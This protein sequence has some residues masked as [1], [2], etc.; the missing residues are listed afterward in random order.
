MAGEI[1]P[2][3]LQFLV[4]RM[5]SAVTPQVI[6]GFLLGLGAQNLSKQLKPKAPPR[7]T[8]P[9]M[10]GQATINKNIPGPG[11]LRSGTDPTQL[12]ALAQLLSNPQIGQ[13]IAKMPAVPPRMASPSVGIPGVQGPTIA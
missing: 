8:Q 12:Q 6:Q 3:L 10:G 5:G 1:N 7:P 2:Q 13:Q 11:P 9:Q 4:Q